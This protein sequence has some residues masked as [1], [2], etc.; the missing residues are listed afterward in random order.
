MKKRFGS[1]QNAFFY[2]IQR[3]VL[4]LKKDNYNTNP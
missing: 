1:S 2:R 3:Q 4:I